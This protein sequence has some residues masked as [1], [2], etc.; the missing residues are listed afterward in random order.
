MMSIAIDGYNLG[1]GPWSK[2]YSTTYRTPRK[3]APDHRSSDNTSSST[4]ADA[5]YS[6]GI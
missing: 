2:T 3:A 5:N 6:E 4:L 1:N